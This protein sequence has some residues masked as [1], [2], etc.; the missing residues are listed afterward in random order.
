MRLVKTLI[1]LALI[2]T[3]GACAHN[4]FRSYYGPK[5]T[6]V[7]VMKA[8]RRMVLYHKNKILSEH[9]IDLGFAPRG[10]KQFEGDG[11]TPE[12]RY[13]I[14]RRNPNSSH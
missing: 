10:D 12:G 1:V 5:V 4:K 9:R 3:L 7:V 14:D 8:D 2:L 6:R 13:F 11:K